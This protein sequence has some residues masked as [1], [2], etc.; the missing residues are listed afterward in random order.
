MATLNRLRRFANKMQLRDLIARSQGE[1]FPL[2][3]SGCIS[4]GEERV[5]ITAQYKRPSGDM[6]CGYV[7]RDNNDLKEIEYSDIV[8]VEGYVLVT[9]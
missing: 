4:S 6:Y 8:T 1:W 5:F 3:A 7:T 9:S 2:L